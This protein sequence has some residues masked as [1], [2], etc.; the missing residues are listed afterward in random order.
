MNLISSAIFL[1]A[2]GIL[3]SLTGALNF[4]ELSVRLNTMQQ[5]GVI[6]AIAILFLGTFGLKSAIFPL[7]FWL[8]ASSLSV[9]HSRLAL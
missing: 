5:P 9:L 8:P 2:V 4:A 7:F 3:Y 1:S 6:T